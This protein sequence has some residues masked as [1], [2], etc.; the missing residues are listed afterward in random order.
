[1]QLGNTLFL[2]VSQ[3]K[4]VDRTLA[5]LECGEKL[6]RKPESG[7][8]VDKLPVSARRSLLR[9][10]CDR[11]GGASEEAGIKVRSDQEFAWTGWSPPLMKYM[12]NTK[13]CSCQ[14]LQVLITHFQLEPCSTSSSCRMCHKRQNPPHVPKIHPVRVDVFWAILKG[15]VCKG[16]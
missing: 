7:R 10:S 15:L 8:K 6:E 2:W 3:E 1:M 12:E 14:T 16:C 9:Q 11:V 13:F 5:K 4:S